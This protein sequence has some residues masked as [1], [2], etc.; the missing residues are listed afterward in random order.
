[1][2]TRRRSEDQAQRQT[3]TGIDRLVEALR[4]DAELF[5]QLSLKPREA[6]RALDYLSPGEKRLVELLDPKDL[7][8]LG[9]FRTPGGDIEACGASCGATCAGS[10]GASCG[11]SCGGSCGGSCGASCVGSCVG[12]C[13]GSCVAS[14]VASGAMPGGADELILPAELMDVVIDKAE[15]AV[16]VRRSIEQKQFSSFA[17]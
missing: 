11:A 4:E 7:V 9:P 5:H 8:T 14:C 2:A 6:M 15:L 12:S 3:A 1:M 13:A 10:C 17:R 16:A